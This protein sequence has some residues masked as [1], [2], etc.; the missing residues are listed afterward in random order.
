MRPEKALEKFREPDYGGLKPAMVRSDERNYA[1]RINSLRKK[2]EL[3]SELAGNVP[4]GLKPAFLS[5]R[6][7]HE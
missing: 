3:A 1:A 6:L 4:Q 2:A 5:R 7:R